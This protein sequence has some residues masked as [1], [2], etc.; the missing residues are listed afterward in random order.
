MVKRCMCG[1]GKE[2]TDPIFCDRLARIPVMSPAKVAEEEKRKAAE[3]AAWAEE[4]KR[5]AEK[6]HKK[7]PAGDMSVFTTR[8]THPGMQEYRAGKKQTAVLS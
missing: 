3:E 4:Q 6:P 1:K 2:C 8:S 7:E 5:L